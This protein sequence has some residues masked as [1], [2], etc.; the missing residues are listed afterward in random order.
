MVRHGFWVKPDVHIKAVAREM[1]NNFVGSL[2]VLE[3]SKLVGIITERDIVR[4]FAQS[5]LAH[6]ML[7]VELP[8]LKDVMSELSKLPG[9]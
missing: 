9:S 4:T 2:L 1:A 7:E 5:I 8:Y 3:E 6:V